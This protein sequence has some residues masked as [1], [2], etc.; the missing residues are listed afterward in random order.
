MSGQ[1]P[2]GADYGKAGAGLM[3]AEENWGAFIRADCD[4][5]SEVFGQGTALGMAGETCTIAHYEARI[6]ALRALKANYLD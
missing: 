3:A 5:V 4:V 2:Q 1:G 6:A